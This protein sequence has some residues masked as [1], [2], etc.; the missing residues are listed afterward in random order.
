MQTP[1]A[2]A[3]RRRHPCDN[4]A[5][6]SIEERLNAVT[7]NLELTARELEDMRT[8]IGEL[9]ASAADLRTSAALLT[10]STANLLETS[11]THE[12]R[13]TRLEGPPS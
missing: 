5:G 12:R 4:G 1:A 2:Q 9:R 7:M 6:M 10:T 8:G 11:E 13:I 3:D